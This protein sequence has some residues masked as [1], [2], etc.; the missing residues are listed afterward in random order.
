MT[1]R[2]GPNEESLF[3]LDHDRIQLSIYLVELRGASG[4]LVLSDIIPLDNLFR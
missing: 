3:V 4:R 2:T 1:V